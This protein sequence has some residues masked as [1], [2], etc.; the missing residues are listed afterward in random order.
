MKRKS[1]EFKKTKKP[2][3]E[4]ITKFGG[5][6]VWL[7]E[8][9]WPI[10]NETGKPMRFICQIELS[11]DIF[12]SRKCKMAYIFMTDEEEYIDGTWEPDGGENAVILQPGTTNIQT[13]PLTEGPT[14]YQM[15]KKMFKKNLV[16]IPCEF[17]VNLTVAEDLEFVP[18]A[19]RLSWEEEKLETYANALDGNKIGGSPIFLQADE[20]PGPN[21]W[22]LI[23]TL[24][25]TNVPF[26][27]N[28]GDSGIGYAFI[29]EE[30]EI[31]KFLWQ[32]A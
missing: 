4:P 10:S 14:I 15:E 28:F 2:I 23:L 21:N 7:N 1:I 25:S 5:S 22:Q 17:A 20:F 12:G 32:C 8:P 18:E 3:H 30:G 26:F 13:Q 24:D 9:Q 6:P 27:I 19:E 16:P 31:G 29:S 11:A